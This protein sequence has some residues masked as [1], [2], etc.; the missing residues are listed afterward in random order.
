MIDTATIKTLLASND[1]A[2]IKGGLAALNTTE[3]KEM[4]KEAMMEEKHKWLQ[5]QVMLYSRVLA[6]QQAKQAPNKDVSKT[7]QRI[8]ELWNRLGEADKAVAQLHKALAI[9]PDNIHS[10]QLLS[11]THVSL[12]EYNHAIDVQKKAIELMGKAET[13]V[14][15]GEMLLGKAQLAT[16]YEAKGEFDQAIALLHECESMCPKEKYLAEVYSRLGQVQQKLGMDA[17]AISTLTKAKDIYVRTKGEEHKKTKEVIY[18]L[19]M[20]SSTEMT[21]SPF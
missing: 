6:L 19:E 3:M 21:N 1:I 9:E 10:L 4:Y 14:A 11:T 17:E 2:A 8:A 12:S 7:Y 13:P 18:L 16:I 15:E 5:I 20:A